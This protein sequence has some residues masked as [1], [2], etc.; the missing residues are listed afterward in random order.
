MSMS[1]CWAGL[2]K[3]WPEANAPCSATRRIISATTDFDFVKFGIAGTSDGAVSG[4]AVYLALSL[5]MAAG[6]YADQTAAD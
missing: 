4:R 1:Q 2:R 5:I 6:L 3:R